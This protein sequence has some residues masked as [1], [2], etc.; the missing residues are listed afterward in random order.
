MATDPFAILDNVPAPVTAQG[1]GHAATALPRTA[2]TAGEAVDQFNRACANLPESELT[3]LLVGHQHAVSELHRNMWDAFASRLGGARRDAQLFQRNGKVVQVSDYDGWITIDDLKS[4]QLRSISGKAIWWHGQPVK[5][6]LSSGGQE[7]ATEGAKQAAGERAAQAAELVAKAQASLEQAQAAAE[8]GVRERQTRVRELDQAVKVAR[9][10][11]PGAE[12]DANV[13]N[14]GKALATAEEAARKASDAVY[15]PKAGQEERN[16]AA[17]SR[18]LATA[19]EAANRTAEAAT[20]LETQGPISGSGLQDVID[21]INYLTPEPHTTLN[22]YP[23]V[24]DKVEAWTIIKLPPNLP[25]RAE[26]EILAFPSEEDLA[27]LERIVDHPVLVLDQD[28]NLRLETAPGYCHAAAAWLTEN[29]GVQLDTLPSCRDA[30]RTFDQLIGEFPFDSPASR[31][32]AYAM[33]I[34]FIVGPVTGA[35]KAFLGDKST[36]RTGATK[37]LRTISW[38]L[39]GRRMELVAPP[40]GRDADEAMKKELMTAAL[41]GTEA[42][43]IDNVVGHF[44]SAIWDAYITSETW[45]TRILGGNVQG[46]VDRTTIVDCITGNG[47]LVSQDVA[48]RLCPIRLDAQMPNPEERIFAFDPEQ[49]A[50]DERPR[51]LKAIVALVHHWLEAGAPVEQKV[52]DFAAWTRVV[53]GI[54]DHASVEGFGQNTAAPILERVADGG[55][56]QFVMAWWNDH[57]ANVVRNSDLLKIAIGAVDSKGNPVDI[58]ILELNGANYQAQGISLGKRLSNMDRKVYRTRDGNVTV[59]RIQGSGRKMEFHLVPADGTV[60]TPVTDET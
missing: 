38:A 45:S 49:L 24:A 53:K 42:V 9:L 57:G 3:P 12:G 13:K 39:T 51:F 1:N 46:Q 59:T 5:E 21:R 23:P 40:S 54:L 37:L 41:T 33:A 7:P 28:G 8:D 4:P 52:G 47:L 36:P 14:A 48:A 11:L 18:A 50:R 31:A 15:G 20:K 2:G 26:C 43:L 32:H 17:A 30:V 25:S 55:E 19:Q 16:I 35:K 27:R 60:W 58:P 34:S 56:D 29:A 44:G 22:Y 6:P 10:N